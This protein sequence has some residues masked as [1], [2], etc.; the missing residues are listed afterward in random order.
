MDWLTGI[1]IGLSFV[2]LLVSGYALR[3]C[4][5]EYRLALNVHQLMLDIVNKNKEREKQNEME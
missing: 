2:A 1:S 3:K 4:N 5:H